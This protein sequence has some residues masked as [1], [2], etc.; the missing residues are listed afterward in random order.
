LSGL[1]V[2]A[3]GTIAGAVGAASASGATGGALWVETKA[4][5]SDALT[6]EQVTRETPWCSLQRAVSAAR[7]GDFV[8]V[9][10]GRYRGTVRP[11]ASGSASAP[12]LFVAPS[13]G[14]TR[15]DAGASVAL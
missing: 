14:V 4:G 11:T 6:R 9:M 1:V 3:V 2:V 15:D 5:C 12:I 13:G 10:P 8:S 7:P